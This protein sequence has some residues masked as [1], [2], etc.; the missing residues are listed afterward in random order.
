MLKK[1]KGIDMRTRLKQI[2]YMWMWFLTGVF[3]VFIPGTCI[4]LGVAYE[5]EGVGLH[6]IVAGVVTVLSLIC[7][8]ILAYMTDLLGE[9]LEDR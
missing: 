8:S 2:I 5:T 1:M 3:T 9:K 4:I 7:A 6:P